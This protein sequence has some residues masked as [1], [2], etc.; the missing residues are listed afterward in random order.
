MIM[1]PVTSIE[2]V[3]TVVINETESK[4]RILSLSIPHTQPFSNKQN[5]LHK[6]ILK[7]KVGA[8]IQKLVELY[9]NIKEPQKARAINF[10]DVLVYG[11]R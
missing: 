5:K 10:V 11:Q 7:K 8:K 9:C 3:N 6:M 4:K 1:F 2:T